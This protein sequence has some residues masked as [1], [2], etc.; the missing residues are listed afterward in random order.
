MQ[1]VSATRNKIV[2]VGASGSQGLTDL[3]EF[4]EAVWEETPATILVVLHR[5]FHEDSALGALLQRGSSIP[6]SLVDGPETLQ[7]GHCYIGHPARHLVMTGTG[8]LDLVEDSAAAYRNATVD[9]LFGSVAEHASETATGIV[10]SGSLSDG[11]RGLAAI[12]AAGGITMARKPCETF[13]SDMARNAIRIAGP[14]G[15]VR[16][17]QELAGYL[18]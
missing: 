6:V 13:L 5:Q 10:L 16:T 8:Q 7:P 3:Y 9:L 12:K 14:L 18:G 2:A 1:T 4:L 15:Q 11:S 17:P